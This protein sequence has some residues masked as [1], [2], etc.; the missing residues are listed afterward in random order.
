MPRRYF[1]APVQGS[2]S[3]TLG[4]IAQGLTRGLDN[5]QTQRRRRKLERREDE[6][7]RPP[8]DRVRGRYGGPGLQEGR[9]PRCAN[10]SIRWSR[11]SRSGGLRR[12][13][14]LPSCE[15]RQDEGDS[16]GTLGERHAGRAGRTGR[17]YRSASH[18]RT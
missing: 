12:D 5:F 3:S 4:G 6:E 18:G 10:A 13:R 2:T 15:A 8:G 9:S 16:D 11:L 1:F 14:R 7:Q 17:R